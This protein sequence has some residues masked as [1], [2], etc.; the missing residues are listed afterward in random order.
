MTNSND[1]MFNISMNY[2]T[3]LNGKSNSTDKGSNNRKNKLGKT[4]TGVIVSLILLFVGVI[5]A[6]MLY[7]RK[8]R[9]CLWKEKD[10]PLLSKED[11]HFTAL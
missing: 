8:H 2:N 10:T 1:F 5:V 7:L 3:T 6:S 4:E 9:Q 11:N